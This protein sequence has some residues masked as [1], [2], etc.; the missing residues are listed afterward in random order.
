MSESKDTV[1]PVPEGISKTQL[2]PAS[3]VSVELLMGTVRGGNIRSDMQLTFQI[4]H[5]AAEH[6]VS[7]ACASLGRSTV[8]AYAYCSVK[9]GQLVVI[10]LDWEEPSHTWVYPRVGEKDREVPS[11][12]QTLVS[13]D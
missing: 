12:K 4:G 13:E 8:V 9:G 1:F 11:H 2:P 5:V 3:S 7:P 6:Q 10:A